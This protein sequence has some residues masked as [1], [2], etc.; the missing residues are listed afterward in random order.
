MTIRISS[1]TRVTFHLSIYRGND[2][3]DE[4]VKY[5]ASRGVQE[6]IISAGYVSYNFVAGS[7][8]AC[9]QSLKVLELKRTRINK[10]D[11]GLWSCLQLLDSLTLSNCY[12]AFGDAADDD[13]FASF[14]RLENL[15]LVECF[16]S[17][18]SVLRVSGGKLRNLEIVWPLFE[19]LEIFAPKLQ[20]FT[21]ARL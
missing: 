14:P 2:R 9:Y 8:Y 15:K 10:I 16:Y 17:G 18:T 21:L 7:V 12:F 4:I 1:V 13:A 11:V 20:S 6:L 3:L 19:N 5:A